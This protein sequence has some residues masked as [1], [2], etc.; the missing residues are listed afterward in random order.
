M[1]FDV[2][3]NLLKDGSISLNKFLF[4]SVVPLYTIWLYLKKIIFGLQSQDGSEEDHLCIKSILEVEESLFRS[5]E[6][7][8]IRWS[9]VQLYR[10]LLVVVLNTFILN[11]IDKSLSYIGV[12]LL[13]LTHDWRRAPYKH[14]Y[15][16]SLQICSTTCLLVVTACNVPASF[17][18]ASNL[19]VIPHMRDLLRTLK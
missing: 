13:F 15:L 2:N 4:A 8:F 6:G 12:F 9:A 10:N 3:L 14:P 5:T 11:P 19:M 16:N 18:S 17:S 1:T 7:R